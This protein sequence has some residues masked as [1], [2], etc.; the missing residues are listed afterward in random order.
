MNYCHPPKNVITAIFVA[1]IG[2]IIAAPAV[3]YINN[4]TQNNDQREESSRIDPEQFV[5]NQKILCNNP[6]S[7]SK[8]DQPEC[9]SSPILQTR[10]NSQ[11]FVEKPHESSTTQEVGLPFVNLD[12][13]GESSLGNPDQYLPNQKILCTN[14]DSISK[15]DQLEC[16]SSPLV[17]TDYVNSADLGGPHK[18]STTRENELPN[19]NAGDRLLH[20][21][22]LP[23][24]PTKIAVS[25]LD[26]S[27]NSNLPPLQ[28]G[29]QLLNSNPL[30]TL[31]NLK[32]HR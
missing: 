3:T 25:P 11:I 4:I 17:Q 10:S 6:N 12:Q 28:Q 29:N 19:I 2:A 13:E 24:I 23:I 30:P 16:I 31:D 9:L 14:Q 1:V 8:S 32:Q 5:P 26:H 15:S 21:N 20:L 22:P 18:I 7:I 27:L